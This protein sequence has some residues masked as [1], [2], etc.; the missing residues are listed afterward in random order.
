MKVAIVKYNAGNTASV[1]NALSRLG[2]TAV[3]TDD[4]AELGSAD[5]VLFPGVGEASSAMVFLRDRGLDKAIR[6]LTQPVLGICLGMQLFCASSEE[7]GT[8]CLGISKLRVERFAPPDLKVPHVG[9]NRVDGSESKLFRGVDNG[10]YLYFVHG[11]FVETGDDTTAVCKYGVNFSAAI[12]KNNFYGV[13][14]HPE[15]SGDAGMEILKN[16][17]NL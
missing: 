12:E 16:F 7:N 3:V 10:E 5:R 4:E 1:V 6:K 13:Q 17:L 14:F 2:T 9:W 8:E 15:K 11:Y